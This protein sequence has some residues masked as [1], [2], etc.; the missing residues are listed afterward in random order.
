MD[1]V[2]ECIGETPIEAV[3]RMHKASKLMIVEELKK[4]R[5]TL[6]IKISLSD[7]GVD[8]YTG[9]YLVDAAKQDY[10]RGIREAHA[11]MRDWVDNGSRVQEIY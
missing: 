2:K 9:R 8:R 1:N 10:S 4:G 5:T 11:E 6:E 7:K 3:V